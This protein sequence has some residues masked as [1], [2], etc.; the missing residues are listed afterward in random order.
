MLLFFQISTSSGAMSLPAGLFQ[1]Q[2][3]ALRPSGQFQNVT[4]RQTGTIFIFSK[5]KKKKL[6]DLL[7]FCRQQLF[8][9]QYWEL[10]V[11]ANSCLLI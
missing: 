9:I 11:L 3:A 6:A 8:Y 1:Q 10:L 4:L 7:H 2:V 5:K